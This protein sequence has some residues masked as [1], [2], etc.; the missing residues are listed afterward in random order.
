MD[1]EQISEGTPVKRHKRDTV[2]DNAFKSMSSN[3][4]E[5]IVPVINEMFGE[6]YSKDSAKIE[7]L[8][9]EFFQNN[10]EGKKDA[11]RADLV[12]TISDKGM[13]KKYH[14]ECQSE[15]DKTM[16][17]RIFEYATQI[18]LDKKTLS[19]LLKPSDDEIT[20]KFPRSALLYLRSWGT[21]PDKFK[22]N[23]EISNQTVVYEIPIMKVKNYDVEEIFEKDLLFLI[24]FH[25]F[26]LENE[27]EKYENNETKLAEL[28]KEYEFIADR[29]NKLY[30]EKRL[31]VNSFLEISGWTKQIADQLAGNYAKV[32]E[33][34]KEA[35]QG[36]MIVLPETEVY[37]NGFDAGLEKGRAEM[38]ERIELATREA[39]I[40][41][42]KYSELLQQQVNEQTEK[43]KEYEARF[44]A[45]QNVDLNAT[46]KTNAG[47]LQQFCKRSL[48]A[49]GEGYKDYVVD[50]VKMFLLTF[51][52]A[53]LERMGNVIDA[54]APE[55]VY[56]TE[57][58]K[59][60]DSV[61][62]AI[63]QDVKFQKHSTQGNDTP[64]GT[65]R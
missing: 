12:L 38:A 29:L 5:L 51:P 9:N 24:P 39:E 10:L 4:T 22:I 45:I 15:V 7:I 30:E 26:A 47:K 40:W 25:L 62:S 32:R 13:P 43:Q 63:E 60:S 54:V 58:S 57:W 20:L 53:K 2:Y 35:M 59:F 6:K 1:E 16:I 56:N 31:E 49:H 50:G 14:I 46:L 28:Q 52:S 27:F 44:N 18:A 36:R 55:A 61:K 19:E 37:Y 41:K 21:T 65:S 23:V 64:N 33:G 3:C 17:I 42:Q 11:K 34:V 8:N 48:Q